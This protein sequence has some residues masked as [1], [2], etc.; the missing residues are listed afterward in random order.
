LIFVVVN[1]S[2]KAKRRHTTGTGRMRYL[3][4][5]HRRFLNGFKEGTQPLSKKLRKSIKIASR[6]KKLEAKANKSSA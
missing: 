2:E 3:K 4:L 1:W 6:Q 5:V